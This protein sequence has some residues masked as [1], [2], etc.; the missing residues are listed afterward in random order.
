MTIDSGF[1]LLGHP[2]YLYTAVGFI[3]FGAHIHTDI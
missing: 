2:V 3:S 1:T